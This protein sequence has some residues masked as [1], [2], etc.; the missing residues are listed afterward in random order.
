MS[1]SL[2][3]IE[4][5]QQ[6]TIQVAKDLLGSLLVRQIG[7]EKL[8]GRIVETEAYLGENDPAC[9][10]SAGKTPRTEIFWGRAGVAYVFL[11][12]GI[13]YCLN[14]ITLPEEEAGC[15]LIRALEPIMGIDRMRRNRGGS[16]D[17][18]LTNGPGKLCQAFEIDLSFTGTD[19]TDSNSALYIAKRDSS[20]FA[21]ETTSRIGIT[22]ATD[23]LLRFTIKGNRFVSR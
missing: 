14:V 18:E 9:H 1:E 8:V 6:D 17:R 5:F 11:I 2:Y 22:K 16:G 12:Y 10:A 15:V 13:Y 4:F 19:L 21:I 7:D 23:E 20:N 3:P